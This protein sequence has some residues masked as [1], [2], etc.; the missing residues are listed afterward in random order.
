MR[1]KVLSEEIE[2]QL[3]PLLIEIQQLKEE[4]ASCK[5]ETELYKKEVQR[6]MPAV[7]AEDLLLKLNS[8]LTELR[9]D[10]YLLN[11]DSFDS[12]KARQVK[13][14]AKFD[15]VLNSCNINAY[16]FEPGA[17][18]GDLSKTVDAN[19]WNIIPEIPVNNRRIN[20]VKQC[21]GM[22]I[23]SEGG[24]PFMGEIG[25]YLSEVA[26]EVSRRIIKETTISDVKSLEYAKPE[27]KN[28]TQVRIL[29]ENLPAEENMEPEPVKTEVKNE[30]DS[31]NTQL[32][33]NT[34]ILPL[35]SGREFSVVRDRKKPAT[36]KFEKST[37]SRGIVKYS[38]NRL[39]SLFAG[40]KYL[41]EYYNLG[42]LRDISVVSV[43]GNEYYL[44]QSNDVSA[45]AVFK[46]AIEEG[47]LCLYLCIRVWGD[48][49][50][51]FVYG[52]EQVIR[53]AQV[54]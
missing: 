54:D 13:L 47:I 49:E 48:A 27:A 50:K 4:V 17:F 24:Q 3:K 26:P 51:S 36:L 5:A 28:V 31:L 32:F 12:I 8:V 20:T 23:E 33:S 34:G 6:A 38:D 40:S 41:G 42:K 43:C 53:L 29:A 35:Y 37:E 7:S 15:A 44:P 9:N 39:L 22:A 10:T 1:R 19:R 16:Y 18:V 2:K 14:W 21:Y 52:N 11:V 25:V 30:A 46:F 45:Q